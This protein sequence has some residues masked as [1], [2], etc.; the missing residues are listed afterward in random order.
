MRAEN[1]SRNLHGQSTEF[2][3]KCSVAEPWCCFIRTWC[4]KGGGQR[5]H[6]GAAVLTALLLPGK[7]GCLVLVAAIRRKLET[8]LAWVFVKRNSS[9]VILFQ[10]CYLMSCE[11]RTDLKLCRLGVRHFIGYKLVLGQWLSKL[12]DGI[13]LFTNGFLCTLYA[14]STAWTIVEIW[15]GGSMQTEQQK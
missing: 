6:V 4:S 14:V 11:P 5:K 3:L 9:Y 8:T 2:T 15:T 12:R 1:G 13:Y 7:I 10:L